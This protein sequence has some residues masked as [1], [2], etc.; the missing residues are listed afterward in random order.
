MNRRNTS[1]LGLFSFGLFG[2]GWIL[3]MLEMIPSAWF[4]PV[5]V[6]SIIGMTIFFWR[7]RIATL[8]KAWKQVSSVDYS[9]QQL[10]K[11]ER[12]YQHA[13]V[14]VQQYA[15]CSGFSLLISILVW[16]KQGLT[17][18]WAIA[19]T[20]FFTM[21]AGSFSAWYFPRTIEERKK[22]IQKQIRMQRCGLATFGLFVGGMI[23]LENRIP[24]SLYLQTSLI[25]T[26]L[27]FV[28]YVLW[29]YWT[30]CIKK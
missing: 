4:F 8:E 23:T 20:V 3:L 7:I 21:G 26:G 15:I 6:V 27:L 25:G 16:F 29:D 11:W 28:V 24:S 19:V 17:I 10:S 1:L 30:W 22:N 9:R 13:P 2:V 12:K 14:M 5:V 18:W